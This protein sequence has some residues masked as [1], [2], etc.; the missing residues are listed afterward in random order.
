MTRS[1]TPGANRWCDANGRDL[2]QNATVALVTVAKG[3]GEGKVELTLP[4][5]LK[6][7]TYTFTINGAGQ[8]PRDYA[9]QRDPSKPRGN[10]VRV[11]YPSNPIT[12]TIEA[13]V[14]AKQ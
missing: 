9:K 13:A 7:G 12:I 3:A 14:K 4:A 1:A 6:P 10:N 8:A 2:P 5:N 11:V